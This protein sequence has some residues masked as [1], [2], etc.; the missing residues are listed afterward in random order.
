MRP[1]VDRE[2]EGEKPNT[3]VQNEYGRP[4]M[5]KKAEQL[6]RRLPTEST[7]TMIMHH[8]NK[9]LLSAVSICA[10]ACILLR[11]LSPFA[12]WSF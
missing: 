4:E 7:L 1:N 9:R 2:V 6:S 3:Y 10:A 5:P 8:G 11:Q 12:Q